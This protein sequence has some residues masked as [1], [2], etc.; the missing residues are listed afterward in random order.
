MKLVVIAVNYCKLVVHVVVE[1]CRR[2][3]SQSGKSDSFDVQR[4][5]EAGADGV[6][7]CGRSSDR[8]SAA[9][10]AGTTPG[11]QRDP[12]HRAGAAVHRRSAEGAARPHWDAGRRRIL[13][14]QHQVSLLRCCTFSAFV[15][16]NDELIM[17]ALCNRAGH[18]IFCPA[19]TSF[20]LFFPRLI[21]AVAD[22][23]SAILPHM[24]W[25]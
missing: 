3:V 12:R 24:V 23:L 6:D 14:R 9:A 25:P 11:D 5:V 13:D 21:S 20:F 17:V 8:R 22:W 16:L 15:G 19:V 4:G 7:R 2:T 18:Y 1:L 10:V